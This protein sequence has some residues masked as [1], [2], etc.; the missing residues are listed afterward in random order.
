MVPVQAVLP[1][2][3]ISVPDT[4]DFQMCAAHDTSTLTFNV[5]NTGSVVLAVLRGGG[6]GGGGSVTDIQRQTGRQTQTQRQRKRERVNESV[7]V[8]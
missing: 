8:V 7:K 3:V 1:K 6:G 5:I 4:L 2:T